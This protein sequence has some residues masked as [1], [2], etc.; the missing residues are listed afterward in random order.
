MQSVTS[1]LVVIV[2]R[3][4]VTELNILCLEDE[5]FLVNTNCSISVLLQYVRAKLEVAESGTS[6]GAYVSITPHVTSPD[7]ALQ[8]LL[9]NQTESLEKTR[10][11][12]VRALEARKTLGEAPAQGQPSQPVSI[13]IRLDFISPIPCH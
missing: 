7:P 5:Q 11:K 12:Q 1:V 8:E 4:S 3:C 13:H 10:L 2:R 9:Q 6:D